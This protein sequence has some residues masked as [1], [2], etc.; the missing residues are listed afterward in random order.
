MT[1]DRA[2]NTYLAARNRDGRNAIVKYDHRGAY[3]T[4]WAA[5]TAEGE[6]GVKTAAVDANGQVYVAVESR[7]L[8]GVQ[9]FSMS[10]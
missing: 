7:A 4:A 9:V 3:A 5:S 2:G 6:Q 1:T 8:H 10:P